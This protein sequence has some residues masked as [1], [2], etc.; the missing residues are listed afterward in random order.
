MAWYCRGVTD[1]PGAL[2]LTTTR[3]EALLRRVIRLRAILIAVGGL[4]AVGVISL[5]DAATPR[6]GTESD[7]ERWLKVICPIG[8]SFGLLYEAWR[9]GA[10][11]P[12]IAVPGLPPEDWR[13]ERLP[14]SAEWTLLALR[15]LGYGLVAALFVGQTAQ[16]IGVPLEALI[17]R[18]GA[19][20]SPW[21]TLQLTAI[22]FLAALQLVYYT[23]PLDR[24]DRRKHVFR[25]V[26]G[27]RDREPIGALL[28]AVISVLVLMA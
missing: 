14:T 16:A 2:P 27:S 12:A 3:R 15:S 19:L 6:R 28:L 17:P 5:G 24:L 20:F 26:D 13:E 1:D 18:Q 9:A 21:K 8:V 10:F 7:I 11:R 23:A 25:C 4:L 22:A